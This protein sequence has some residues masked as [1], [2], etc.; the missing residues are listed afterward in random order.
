M[1]RNRLIRT[2][3]G[4]LL[5]L[6]AAWTGWWFYVVHAAIG[7]F[8]DWA[9]DRRAEGWDIGFARI[10]SGGY[11]LTV[12]LTVHHGGIS[13]P[14]R[15]WSVASD[16]LAISLRPWRFDRYRLESRAAV[17]FTSG[18][19][20]GSRE[21][22]LTAQRLSGYYRRDDRHRLV[23]KAAQ[24]TGPSG[25]AAER[26]GIS[27]ARPIEAPQ[28]TRAPI[29]T[30]RAEVVGAALPGLLPPPLASRFGAATL[31][32]TVSGPE[33]PG[34]GSMLTRLEAWRQGG[35]KI[36]VSELAMIW[37]ELTLRGDGT[38]TVDE[39]MRPL[40]AFT[41]RV[42]G[43]EAAARR[44]E[45]AGLIDGSTRRS[46]ELGGG[47]L[48]GGGDGRVRFP[49]AIQDGVFYLGPAAMGK[50]GPIVPGDDPAAPAVGPPPP[51]AG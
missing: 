33:P 45:A 34:E 14:G 51:T 41:I 27:I 20:R 32:A 38:V 6:T 3:A 1:I 7:G 48:S 16:A 42:S 40:A 25:F 31:D 12:R 29:L 37:E 35:G 43:L 13:A 5:L 50:V 49:V 47:L 44:A 4:G 28:D 11:P 10:E 18:A 21:T 30:L 15:L 9:A 8:R 39:A 22:P 26:I 2:V 23:L 17:E 46:I 19:L 36:D 24:V